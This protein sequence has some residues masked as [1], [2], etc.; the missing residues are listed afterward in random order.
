MASPTATSFAS[1]RPGGRRRF[2]RP[3]A[4]TLVAW[5]FLLQFIQLLVSGSIF[6]PGG[7]VDLAGFEPTREPGPT[8]VLEVVFV[9]L[10]LLALVVS[11]GLFRLKRWAWLLAMTMEGLNLANALLAYRIGHPEYVT[12][13]VGVVTV[14]ALNQREVRQFFLPPEAPRA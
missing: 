13:V 14:L 10:G 4:V 7:Q 9:G 12:M 6:W 8:L 2:R 5:L 3:S 1:L 11:I